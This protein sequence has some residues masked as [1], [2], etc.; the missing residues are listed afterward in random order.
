MSGSSHADIRGQHSLAGCREIIF[1]VGIARFIPPKGDCENVA[2]PM[3]ALLF[4]VLLAA[5][6]ARA[7]PEIRS[8]TPVIEGHRVGG[9]TIDLIGNIYVADFGDI[10]WKVT[11]EGERHEFASGFYGACGNA[12]DSEGNLL[13]SNFYGNSITKI[14]R[15]GEPKL[16][17]TSGLS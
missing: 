2:N 1:L 17:I 10:V 12:I 14:N 9:V 16:F 13:Q 4:V 11:P 5:I 3:K 8:L 6:P 7:Q 15:K